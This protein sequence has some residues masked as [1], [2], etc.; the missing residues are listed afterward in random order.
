[1]V[2]QS[3]VKRQDESSSLSSS[4]EVVLA[5]MVVCIRLQIERKKFES[6][7]R[8]K[9]LVEKTRCECDEVGEPWRSVKPLPWG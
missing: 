5:D 4:A 8:L 1:M 7:A 9:E 6:S 2:E 3:P